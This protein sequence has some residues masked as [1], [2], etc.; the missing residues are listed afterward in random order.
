MLTGTMGGMLTGATVGML[1]KAMGGMLTGATAGAAIVFCQVF[2]QAVP[3]LVPALVPLLVP[4]PV[5][6]QVPTAVWMVLALVLMQLETLVLKVGL[7]TSTSGM[8]T[9]SLSTM[10]AVRQQQGTSTS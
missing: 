3:V 4:V 8:I 2:A 5:P 10:M 6:V 7:A 1:T 9:A